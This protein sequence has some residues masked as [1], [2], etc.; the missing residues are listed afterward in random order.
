VLSAAIDLLGRRPQANMEE[1]AAA[2][3]VARQTVYAHYTSREKLL[4]AI[5]EHIAAET[6]AVF[7]RL[8]LDD[9]PAPA[10]L[11]RWVEA[12]WQIL[13]R[14]PIVLTEAVAQPPGDEVD[15]HL[16]ISRRLVELLERG[17]TAGQFDNTP[18]VTW[19]IAAIVALGH[20]AGQEVSAGRMAPAAAGEAF[21]SGVLRLCLRSTPAA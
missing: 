8:D 11:D 19:Q 20:A 16:P 5:L 15:R 17:R 6:I 3:G 21:R 4:A 18:P 13:A 12:S 9:L 7:D 1:I 2:A 14:Y 10:A